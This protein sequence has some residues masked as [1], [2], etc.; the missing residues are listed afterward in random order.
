MIWIK[1][2]IFQFTYYLLTR[3]SQSK[4]LNVMTWF[5]HGDA[6]SSPRVRPLMDPMDS[7]ARSKCEVLFHCDETKHSSMELPLIPPPADILATTVVATTGSIALG[8][9]A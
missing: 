9:V 5:G 4:I 2:T 3:E 8:T 7:F 1:V 6:K